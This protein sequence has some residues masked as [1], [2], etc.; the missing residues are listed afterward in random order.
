MPPRPYQWIAQ[1]YDHLFEFRRPFD[2]AHEAIIYPLL[3]NVSSACDLCCG[4]GAT[5]LNFANL[6]ITAFGIDLSPEMC[7]QT[8]AKARQMGLPVTVIEADMRRFRLPH[9]VDLITCEFDALNHVARKQDLHRVLACAARA[10][11]PGGYFIFDVNNRSSF[12]RTWN[13][14]WHVDKDPV[15]LV[16]AGTHKPGADEAVIDLTW[17]VR[18]GASWRRH[19][20]RVREVCW[21][22]TEIREALTAAGFHQIRSFDAAPFFNDDFTPRGARTFYRARRR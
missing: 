11:N 22:A 7:R 15:F 2:R 4:T 18:H 13:R 9:P 21:S 12:A 8:R 17:F 1:Y 19:Q 5:L 16:M 10:L 14:T 3:A 6:G 20:E